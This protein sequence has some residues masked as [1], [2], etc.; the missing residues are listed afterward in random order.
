MVLPLRVARAGLALSLALA[1]APRAAAQDADTAAKI[2]QA[3]ELMQAGKPAQAIPLY[4]ELAA[5]FPGVPS[6]G[7]NVAIAQFKAGLY[8]AAIAQCDAILKLRP[9]LFSAWLFLGASYAALDQPAR[10]VEPLRKAVELDPEDRN[11]RVMLAE[12]LLGDRQFAGAA[13]QFEEASR[14]MP[15]NSRVWQGTGKSYDAL[16]AE[17]FDKLAHAAPEAAETAALAGE[18]ERDRDQW[19]RAFERYRRALALR[20]AFHGLHA[21]VA[22]IYEKT[23]HPDWAS[24]ERALEPETPPAACGDPS[25][26]CEFSKGLLREVVNA[27]GETPAALYW[28]A[29][30]A[31]ELARRAWAKL[32][33]L[34]ASPERFE[35]VALAEERSGR[36]R[37]A[38]AA[39]KQ[40]LDLAPANT[41]F[42]RQ[43]ALALCRSN[44][45]G[46]ALPL[47]KKLLDGEPASAEWN[48]LYGT[49][50]SSTQNTAQALPY[51]EA[52]VKLDANLIAAR[53]ALGEAYLVAGSPERA[54]PELE[55]SLATDDDGA[56]RYQLARAYQAVGKTQQAAAVLRAYREIL[57]RREA[58]AKAEPAIT[59]P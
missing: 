5:A 18:S 3:T 43:L 4:R 55:V 48:Y 50:L 16:A 41:A 27:A 57:A 21:A 58:Q 31:H 44:D 17:L 54:I 28:R 22:E 14:R 10:A 29:R 42:Q 20:P 52:A 33:E 35:A 1:L 38:A 51:L 13:G 49:A 30:A 34:P 8:R 36:Y 40:A 15:E 46:S 56:R 2:R 23:G 9:D 7:I 25:L 32:G 59:P 53:A 12:A 24:A 37:E 39:W 6:F 11:A 47:I 26:E 19:A 45:C